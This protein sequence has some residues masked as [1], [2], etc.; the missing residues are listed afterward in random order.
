MVHI[1]IKTAT[2]AS[3]I[4]HSH[5]QIFRSLCAMMTSKVSEW[6]V[7]LIICV[8]DYIYCVTIETH[9]NYSEVD[10]TLND[11]LIPQIVLRYLLCVFSGQNKS[12]IS[13]LDGY[14]HSKSPKQYHWH[15]TKLSL[16]LHH[17][18]VFVLLIKLVFDYSGSLFPLSVL[19]QL[20][21][22]C[23][24][25][26]SKEK[27]SERCLLLDWLENLVSLASFHVWKASL[28]WKSQSFY[29]VL[30]MSKC[31]PFLPAQLLFPAVLC[32]QL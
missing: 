23:L 32:C 29:G 3:F 11:I 16:I 21:K 20:Q 7:P 28:K 30:Q 13:C 1:E 18:T 5:P 24:L 17:I 26:L 2:V 12:V 25:Y 14:A 31:S 22:F 8:S 19:A 6:F 10:N 9:L 15:W 27:T 4:L